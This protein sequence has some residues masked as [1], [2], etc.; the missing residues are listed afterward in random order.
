M[1]EH[2]QM[3][4]RAD[5]L[6]MTLDEFYR[7]CPEPIENESCLILWEVILSTALNDAARGS[8]KAQVWLT[9][10][11]TKTEVSVAEWALNQFNIDRDEAIV[12]HQK[13]HGW[14]DADTWKRNNKVRVHRIKSLE[15]LHQDIEAFRIKQE[16]GKETGT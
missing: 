12:A 7:Y 6:G 3:Q 2:R 15:E 10:R 9:T 4:K 13:R 11:S 8:S 5:A 16:R 1:K 14:L